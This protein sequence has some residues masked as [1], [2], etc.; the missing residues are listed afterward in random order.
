MPLE[1]MPKGPPG[2]LDKAPLLKALPFHG[3]AT[4]GG[5][6]GALIAAPIAVVPIIGAAIGFGTGGLMGALADQVRREPSSF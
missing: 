2:L 6:I 4:V 3:L 1:P 5:L